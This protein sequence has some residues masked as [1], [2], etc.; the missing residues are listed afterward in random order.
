MS[1]AALFDTIPRADSLGFWANQTLETRKVAAFLDLDKADVARVSNVSVKS[2]RFDEKIPAEVLRHLEQ[3]AII[4]ALVA[5]FFNGDATKTAM[6]FRTTNPM[7]G[8]ISPRDMIRYGRM[9]KLLQIVQE[10]RLAN[11]MPQ[12]DVVVR[13]EEQVGNANVERQK[14]A[15]PRTAH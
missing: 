5:E 9:G 3:V 2:V 11:G 13:I 10:A 7:L 8:E 4:C 12:R 1:A 15:P 6:W 14:K